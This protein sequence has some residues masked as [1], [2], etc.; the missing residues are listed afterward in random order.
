MIFFP[1]GDGVEANRDPADR[2]VN[3]V[4]ACRAVDDD[5]RNRKLFELPQTLPLKMG[6]GDYQIGPQ[7]S[8]DFDVRL[9]A[10]IRSRE[11]STTRDGVIAPVGAAYK[12][13]TL[14]ESVENFAHVG[15]HR[16]NP[17]RNAGNGDFPSVGVG[18]KHGI[19][20]IDD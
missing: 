2:L 1:F 14:A 5:H 9:R 15:S 16:E 18:N 12:T 17:P 4:E 11:G 6:R 10:G 7:R 19:G 8:G 3:A 20:G 13:L